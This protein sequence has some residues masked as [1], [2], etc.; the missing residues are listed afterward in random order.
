MSI[1]RYVRANCL[2]RFSVVSEGFSS[3]S[4]KYFIGYFFDDGFVIVITFQPCLYYIQPSIIFVCSAAAGFLYNK[5]KV[6]RQVRFIHIHNHCL[7][8]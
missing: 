7:F 2:I 4:V 3:S 5:V 1:T 8:L 6:L